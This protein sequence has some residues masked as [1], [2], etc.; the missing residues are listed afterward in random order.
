[1]R[2]TEDVPQNLGGS[3]Q[4]AVEGAKRWWENFGR[5]ELEQGLGV[6]IEVGSPVDGGLVISAAMMAFMCGRLEIDKHERWE[7]FQQAM[8]RARRRG[9]VVVGGDD[10]TRGVA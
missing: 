6:T 2:V 7:R 9:I 5:R 10:P 1:M 3:L 8:E 4:L